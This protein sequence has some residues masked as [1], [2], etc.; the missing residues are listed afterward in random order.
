LQREQ[1]RVESM[2]T[3]TEEEVEKVNLQFLKTPP[4]C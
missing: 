2:N 1:G 3:E 4:L